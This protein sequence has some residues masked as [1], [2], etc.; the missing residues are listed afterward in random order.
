MFLSLLCIFWRL[1]AG[2]KTACINLCAKEHNRD[3][4]QQ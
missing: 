1:L 4:G 2:I 3:E